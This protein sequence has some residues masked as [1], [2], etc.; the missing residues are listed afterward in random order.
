MALINACDI[1]FGNKIKAVGCLFHFGQAL[2]RKFRTN[3]MLKEKYKESTNDLYKKL[4]IIPWLYE[5]NNG[6]VEDIFN[7]VI[8]NNKDEEYKKLLY[9]YFNYFKCEG[10]PFLKDGRLNKR[11]SHSNLSI[12]PIFTK[13]KN[14]ILI[15][16]ELNLNCHSI[17]TY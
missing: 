1:V 17:E 14:F 12:T 10:E 2:I 11:T 9:S 13:P 4:I 8:N 3:G 7:E 16:P 5:K 6:V 15:Y